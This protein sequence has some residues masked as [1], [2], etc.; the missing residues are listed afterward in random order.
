[1]HFYS[2][3]E[4]TFPSITICPDYE[5]AYKRDILAKFRISVDDFRRKLKFPEPSKESESLGSLFL[6]VTH[7]LDEIIA[8]I[9]FATGRKVPNTNFSFFFF[10]PKQ[11][12]SSN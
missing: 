4:A 6:N 10:A 3:A 7:D 1:M 9:I 11:D 5:N 12:L 2:T 8:K